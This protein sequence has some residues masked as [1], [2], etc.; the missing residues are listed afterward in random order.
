VV[1][2]C[3]FFREAGFADDRCGRTLTENRGN[4]RNEKT[5]APSLLTKSC[6]DL[7]FL[8]WLMCS[9]ATAGA[10]P[11]HLPATI[12]S[13]GSLR[14][15]R[16]ARK[17]VAAGNATNCLQC[18]I[19]RECKYSA[20][21]IYV[22]K[23]LDAGDLTWPVHIVVPDIEEVHAVSGKQA[24]TNKLLA[25]LAED[26]GPDAPAEEVERRSWYG[27]C[28]WDGDNNVIDDQTVTIAWNDD[29]LPGGSAEVGAL[30]G[31]GAKTALL[32]MVAF[33]D[34]ICARRGRIY[35]ADGEVSYDSENIHVFDFRTGKTKSYYVPAPPDAGHGGG[36]DALALNMISAVLAVRRGEMGVH[37]AQWQ[38]LGCDLD[39]ML[40]SHAAVFAAEEA[41]REG[42]VVD[43]ASWWE[44]AVVGQLEGLG[45]GKLELR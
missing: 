19:E 45:L 3:A 4:W 35:G 31:R 2:L 38:H 5:S 43:W 12:S 37:E 30:N 14:Y 11:P 13:T 39:E 33:T 25:A 15:F 9:P 17:P 8:L 41:R 29:P 40:R 23:H 27:R 36:D 44:R 20:K 16:K 34:A 6:H 24:A 10:E 18:P 21:H 22:E 28:V 32:H 7:D 42:V 26:Y 1:A